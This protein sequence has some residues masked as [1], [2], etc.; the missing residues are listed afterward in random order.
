MWRFVSTLLPLLLLAEWAVPLG[1][2]FA[3]QS[4]SACCRRSDHTHSC[5]RRKSSGN[6]STLVSQPPCGSQC[7]SFKFLRSGRSGHVLLAVAPFRHLHRSSKIGAAE[8]VNPA[9]PQTAHN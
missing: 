1:A 8:R 6:G 7:A 9:V 4:N 5:C 3:S 2:Y